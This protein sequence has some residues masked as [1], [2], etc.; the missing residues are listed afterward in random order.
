MENIIKGINILEQIPIKE[1]TTTSSIVCA[2]GIFMSLMSLGIFIKQI[3]SKKFIDIDD[4]RLKKLSIKVAL[5]SVIIF[6]S[7]TPLPIFY[8]ETGRYIYKCKFDDYVSINYISEYFK[9]IEVDENGVWT[10]EE[11]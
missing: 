8:A 5:G 1:Y 6:L 9:I 11:K 3:A 7:L 2:I 10:I 4:I